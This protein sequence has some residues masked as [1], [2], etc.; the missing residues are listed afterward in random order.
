MSRP[1]LPALCAL[2]LACDSTALS[3][4]D[5]NDLNATL[6]PSYIPPQEDI[7][8]LGLDTWILTMDAEDPADATGTLS[9]F[10]ILEADFGQ[11][12]G[13]VGHEF[14]S[15]FVIDLNLKRYAEAVRGTR[16]WSVQFRNH[17]GTFLAHGELEVYE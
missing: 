7:E 8:S 15:N 5:P 12:I 14:R 2:L 1:V 16:K 10:R 9:Q 3:L 6:A 13:L 17:Y 11:G 4:G